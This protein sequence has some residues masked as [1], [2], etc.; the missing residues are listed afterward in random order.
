MN[1]TA[2]AYHE[3]TRYERSKM[4]G[5]SLDW[6]NQPDVFKT[7]AGGEFITMPR[8]MPLF[9]EDLFSLGKG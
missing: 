9:R 8:E 7:Y 6:Q 5:H 1:E 4:G 2:G 3:K